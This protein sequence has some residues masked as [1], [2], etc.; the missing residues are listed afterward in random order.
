MKI[1]NVKG[2]YQANPTRVCWIFRYSVYKR[3]YG[4]PVISLFRKPPQT[5]L[6]RKLGAAWETHLFRSNEMKTNLSFG[7]P[8]AK[9]LYS[10][11]CTC[12]GIEHTPLLISSVGIRFLFTPLSSSCKDGI[13]VRIY[14]LISSLE[15]AVDE[16]VGRQREEN[17][18]FGRRHNYLKQIQ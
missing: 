13:N 9:T 1:C 17:G 3:F 12:L 5:R 8:L 14:F 2:F 10:V 16:R 15:M 11:R 4:R 18:A 7:M 6:L